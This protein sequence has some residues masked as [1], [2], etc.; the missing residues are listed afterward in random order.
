MAN[1]WECLPPML[2]AYSNTQIQ[3]GGE[4]FFCSISSLE[5]LIVPISDGKIFLASTEPV[6]K[7]LGLKSSRSRRTFYC[8]QQPNYK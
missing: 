6:Q 3:V 4:Q 8:K 1:I 5:M 2:K 7:A